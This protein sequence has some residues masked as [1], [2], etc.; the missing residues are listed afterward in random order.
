MI[1]ESL[2]GH[3]VDTVF[4]VPGESYLEIMDALYDV[5]GDIRLI[6]CRHEHGASNMAEA[7][8]KLTGRPGVCMVTRGPGACN[9]SI[10]VHTAKQDSTPMVLLVGQV[11][12]GNMDRESFQEVDFDWM[13]GGLAKWVGTLE[14]VD[15]IPDMMARAFRAACSGRPG[16][17]VLALPE[18]ILRAV[19]SAAAVKPH[20]ITEIS[21]EPDL[22]NQV[23]QK[24]E[25]ASRPVIMVG[26]SGWSDQARSDILKFAEA[27]ALPVCCSFRRHDIMDN[28]HPN[29]I[30]ELGI[31]PNPSLL[32]RIKNAD[33]VLAVGAR[34]CEMTTQDYTLLPHSEQV[35]VH[36]HA[37]VKE[38][39][40]VFPAALTIQAHSARFADDAARTIQVNPRWQ[41]WTEDA[42]RDYEEG[43]VPPAVEGDLDLGQV[44]L[45]LRD[46]LPDGSVVTVD[47]GN[48]SGWPQ[49]FLSY[50]PRYRML[51]PT[52]G[53]MGYAVPAAIAAKA[54]DPYR[55]VVVCVGD[56]SFG[57]TG[58]EIATA[59]LYGFNPVILVFNN[60]MYG[61]IRL[62]QE[63]RHPGRTIGTNLANPDYAALAKSYGAYGETVTKTRD[64]APAYERAVSSNKPAVI[65][66]RMNPDHISTRISLSALQAKA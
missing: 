8:G 11:P 21:P 4:C 7:Y 6:S 26:G 32:Q 40:R 58:Q 33:L 39:G 22:L 25:N 36:V 5:S 52:S 55:Q 63:K 14:T 50:G 10:G 59:M 38:L 51:A 16:P 31:A 2:L 29:F 46:R 53:A 43:L 17:A 13:F 45:T 9:A 56:G 37:D 3:G 57:M 48:A 64:F 34:L 19:G 54:L 30:G 20:R 12:T 44:M 49:R 15:Q 42:R 27:N 28:R 23:R 47:A 66:L 24:L 1:V 60:G 61:T 18:D 62:H 65:E 35:L 41:T